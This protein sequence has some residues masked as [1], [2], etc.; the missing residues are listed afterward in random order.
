[1]EMFDPTRLSR[2]VGEILCNRLSA[3]LGDYES[4]KVDQ[5]FD[6]EFDSFFLK[7]NGLVVATLFAMLLAASAGY[8]L[9]RI[10]YKK[11]RKH[12]NCIGVFFNELYLMIRWSGILRLL[13]FGLFQTLIFGLVQIREG[14]WHASNMNLLSIS[15]AWILV[16]HGFTFPILAFNTM[17]FGTRSKKDG[18]FRKPKK[19]F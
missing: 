7:N 9:Q 16:I 14:D 10:C 12:C 8:I 11:K 18:H 15:I 6:R 5:G 17:F 19:E 13:S 3:Y 4:R 1:M 2:F